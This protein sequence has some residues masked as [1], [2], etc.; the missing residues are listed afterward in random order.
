MISPER[1]EKDIKKLIDQA[2]QKYNQE[3][4]AEAT[5]IA[6]AN[7]KPKRSRKPSNK[8]EKKK[9]APGKRPTCSEE[10]MVFH[11]LLLAN[12]F[13]GMFGDSRLE[14][15]SLVSGYQFME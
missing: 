5:W 2:K 7:P 11:K 8:E 9:P 10:L 12:C 6:K 1:Q 13:N 4:L 15:P 3:K 14:G